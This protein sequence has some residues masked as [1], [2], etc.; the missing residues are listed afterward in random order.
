VQFF[1][2]LFA[3]TGVEET[4]VVGEGAKGYDGEGILLG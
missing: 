3:G 1:E 4:F 2:F